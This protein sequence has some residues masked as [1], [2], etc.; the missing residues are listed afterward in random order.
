MSDSSR[1][2][3]K[4]FLIVSPASM[5]RERSLEFSGTNGSKNKSTHLFLTVASSFNRQGV[6][7]LTKFNI[8]MRFEKITGNRLRNL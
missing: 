3:T 8:K 2:N 1:V 5:K 6:H 4:K 7:L